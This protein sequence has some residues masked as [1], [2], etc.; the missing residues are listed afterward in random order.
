MTTAQSTGTL[1]SRR[2]VQFLLYDWLGADELA[3]RE[4]FEGQSREL[5]DD[6]LG[7]AEQVAT[8]QFAPHYRTADAQEPYIGDDGKVVLPPE[9]E[10]ALRTL[11]ETGLI[12]AGMSEEVGG[13]QLPAVITTAAFSWLY[14]ANVPTAG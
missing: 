14:A 5:Y 7:L 2:D 13:M 9:V 11:G 10:P 1:L 4:R 3:G 12:G 6:V 8:E